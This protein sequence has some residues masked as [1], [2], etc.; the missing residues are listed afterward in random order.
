[1]SLRTR[2]FI[3]GLALIVFSLLFYTFAISVALARLPGLALGWH[4]AFYLCTVL[5]WFGPAALII[6]WIGA[7]QLRA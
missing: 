1:M 5:I 7:R 2:K 3:G 4:L 6:R